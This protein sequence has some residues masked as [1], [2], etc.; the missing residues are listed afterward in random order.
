MY[1]IKTEELD[2][3][4]LLPNKYYAELLGVTPQYISNMLC[5]K[6]SVKA[7]LA[8]CVISTAYGIPLN[9]YQID[10]LLKKH[11]IEEK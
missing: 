1:K 5:G 2:R 11:F 3:I 7:P 9:N 8:K 6:I 10:E 4:G